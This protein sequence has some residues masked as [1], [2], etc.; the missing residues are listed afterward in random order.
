MVTFMTDY[1][2]PGGAE[3]RNPSGCLLDGL[4]L[5]GARWNSHSG[6]LRTQLPHQR[7]QPLPILSV[8]VMDNRVA[9]RHS[10]LSVPVYVTRMRASADGGGL[11]FEA[12]LPIDEERDASYWILQGVC[13]LLNDD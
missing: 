8:C 1:T 10:T 11:V 3:K 13:L 12:D 9:K 5:E 6:R 2:D 4:F 7:I